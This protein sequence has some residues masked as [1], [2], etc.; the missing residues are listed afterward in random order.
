MVPRGAGGASIGGG[1][2]SAGAHGL[3]DDFELM[4]AGLVVLLLVLDTGVVLQEELAGLLENAPA[5]T[6]GAAG[7]RTVMKT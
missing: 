1:G 4:G 6:D 3:G 7:Q 5:L 2:A